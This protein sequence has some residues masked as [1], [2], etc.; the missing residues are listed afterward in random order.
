LAPALA[1]PHAGRRCAVYPPNRFLSSVN[2]G[3]PL[4]R[5]RPP[6]T[7]ADPVSAFYPATRMNPAQPD[8]RRAPRGGRFTD[9]AR[10]SMREDGNLLQS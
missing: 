5:Y 9:L 4:E 6:P 3:S 8:S 7:V 2:R 1:L 10:I